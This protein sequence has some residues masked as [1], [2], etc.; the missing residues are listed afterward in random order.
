MVPRGGDRCFC[1][2]VLL[3]LVLRVVER[4]LMDIRILE[5]VMD[6]L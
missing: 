1:R 5:A 3:L 4:R 6:G 2:V